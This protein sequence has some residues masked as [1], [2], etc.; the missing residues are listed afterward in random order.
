L[1]D[2][3]NTAII[4]FKAN[5]TY[6]YTKGCQFKLD[7]LSTHL[8]HHAAGTGAGNMLGKIENANAIENMFFLHVLTRHFY[9]FFRVFFVGFIFGLSFSRAVL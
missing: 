1:L 8:R 7:N 5:L 9:V 4:N 3:I 2:K 6:L